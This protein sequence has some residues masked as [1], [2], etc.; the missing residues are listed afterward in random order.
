MKSAMV[1]VFSASLIVVVA[2]SAQEPARAP[3]ALPAADTAARIRLVLAPE[4]N[5]A[6]YRVR[7]QLAEVPL[8]N[9]AV[10]TTKTLTGSIVLDADGGLVPGESRFT[11]DL[12]PL[13]SDRERRDRYVQRR[14]LETDQ[15][16]TAVLVPTELR[17]V[18]VPLPTSGAVTFTLVGD[19]TLHGVT[20][21]TTWEVHARAAPD[22]FTGM[23]TTRFTFE[24]FGLSQ[25][26]VAIVLSVE[27]HIELEYDFHLVRERSAAR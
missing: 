14:I 17:G 25:P 7:E 23:A 21:P 13:T 27:D 22:G 24:D 19:L 9:D 8:P 2:A 16:P 4:G 6:R 18:P 12:T 20:R 15:Y 11:V 10:G 1:A 5:E 26:R 3:S